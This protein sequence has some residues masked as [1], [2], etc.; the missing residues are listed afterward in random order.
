LI[1]ASDDE[2]LLEEALKARYEIQRELGHGGMATVYLARDIKHDRVVAIKVLR[3]ELTAALGAERFH[4]EISIAAQLRHP[5]IL[6]LIDSG[7]AGGL[8]YYVM[9]FVNGESLRDRLSRSGA[10][11]VSEAMRILREVVDALVHAHKHGMIHRDIK[12]ENVMIEERH[13]LVVDFGV[14]KAMSGAASTGNLTTVGV[15]LGT[16]QYMSPEQA[17]GETVDHRTDIYAA[18][19]LA[20]EMIA[21]KPPFAGTTQQL[22]SAHVITTPQPLREVAPTCPPAISRIVMKCVEKKPSDRYQTA[23]ELLTALEQLATPEKSFAGVFAR[24]GLVGNPMRL[25]IA[26]GVALIV[27]AGI[28][29]A[30]TSR[31]RRERWARED[32]LPRMQRYIDAGMND[33]AFVVATEVAA[34]IPNDSTLKFLWPRLSRLAVFRTEPEGAKVYRSLFADTTNWVLVGTTPTDSIRSPIGIPPSRLRIIKTGFRTVDRLTFLAPA[35]T[36]MLQADS[37][38][39]SEMVHVNGGNFAG[40]L[41]GLDNLEA[42]PLSGFLIDRREVSN[43]DYKAFVAAGGYA[44][45]DLWEDTFEQNGRAMSWEEGVAMLVDKTG[46]PGPATWEVGDFPS[47]HADFPVGGISWYEARAYAKFVGKS[48]PTLFHWGRAATLP[49]SA[50]II[51][52]SNLG[53]Q[54]PHAVTE[55]R[56]MSGSGTFDMAGNVREWVSNAAGSSRYIL[57]GGWTD[58]SYAF[59]DAYSQPPMDRSPINGMR[60]VK[61]LKDEPNLKFA[62]RP[63]ARAFRDYATEKPVSDA[64]FATFLR[65]YDYDRT[66]LNARVEAVD[67]SIGIGVRHTISFD[68]AYGKERVT[69]HLFLPKVGRP[70]YQTVMYFPGS[71]AMHTRNSADLNFSQIDFFLKSGRAFMHPI[72]KATYERGD[73]STIKSDY[74]NESIYYR[75]Y[76]LMWAKD[77]QRSIDYLATRADIDTARIAYFGFSWGGYMGGIMSVID[78]RVKAAVLYVAGLQMESSR[79]EVDPLNFLPRMKVPVLMLNGSNDHYFPVETSQKPFFRLIGSPP[80]QKRQ[81][82]YEGGHFV[83][84]TQLI[85]ET[86]GWLDKYLGPVR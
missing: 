6:T 79:P 78:P 62:Q 22:M 8:L 31:S 17:A 58:P 83:P 53:G 33:S 25:A 29:Y 59:V 68:A 44:R 64:E 49:L 18:G 15:S 56:A 72:Y 2:T 82:I 23:E 66:P 30:L 3:R 4:R 27:A 71:G 55:R 50:F 84:R 32:A 61:Y 74:T 26:V 57:G 80:G 39:D 11:P 45:K 73:S 21:G 14:A 20:Y 63:L 51:P 65:M 60:L 76:V 12:P 69:A 36:F 34:V 5:N 19:L 10:L 67:S 46:R 24:G 13:A 52:L 35:G 85:V 37:D 47:G 70:P 16:P 86:L 81:V 77:F 75:D 40:N 9:P 41:P 38:P 7:E 54:G 42:I 43:R 1:P 48:L 28:A